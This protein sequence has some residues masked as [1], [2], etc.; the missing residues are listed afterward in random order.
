[1]GTPTHRQLDAMRFR[2][3]RGEDITALDNNGRSVL[4]YAVENA[5]Q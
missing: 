1:M 4:F 3:I 2:L 5:F